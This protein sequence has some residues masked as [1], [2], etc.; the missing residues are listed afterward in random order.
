MAD[1]KRLGIKVIIDM[2]SPPGGRYPNRNLA[3]CYEMQYTNE[4]VKVWERIA[5]HFKGHPALW[6]FDLIN[7]PVQNMPAETDYLTLQ[8]MAAKAIRTIDP[9]VPII[10]A[11]NLWN[12]PETYSYLSPLPLKNIIYQVHMYIPGS[13]T[14]Q[15]VFNTW[16]VDS[17]PTAPLTYPGIIE[18]SKYDRETLRKRLKPV[19]DFQKKYGTRMYVGEFSAIRWAPG[20]ANYL[21]DCISLFEEYQWDWSYHSYREWHGWS[22]EH[23]N[24]PLNRKPVTQDTDRKKVL[25]KYFT[26]NRQNYDITISARIVFKYKK[27][28]EHKMSA[29]K[30]FKLITSAIMIFSN[31]YTYAQETLEKHPPVNTAII[32][33]DP[34]RK[35]GKVNPLIFGNNIEAANGKDIFS[36]KDTEQPLNGQG[37]WNTKADEPIPEVVYIAKEVRMG[38]LRY[39]GG[40]L[41]H[42]FDWRQAVGSKESRTYFKFGIDEYIKLC[43]AIGAEPLMTVSEICTPEDAAD[44]VEYLNMP[45]TP[46]YP[47]AMKRAEWGNNCLLYTSDAADDTPCVDL[48]GRRI[49]KKKKTTK[50]RRA[51]YA[52][53]KNYYART[54]KQH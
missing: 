15:N 32:K 6:G 16:G 8:F 37:A 54:Y 51:R 10:I 12:A 23:S 40:C 13:Y 43:R 35:T 45:A 11:S 24:D 46:Q 42:N 14:H 4:F 5:T 2:H 7:E 47:W 53:L 18:S 30:N 19:I 26:R 1:A 25:L 28:G 31:I 3:M 20:A 41:T 52:P 49:I 39:P 38:M 48:G 17:T 36:D 21:D 27:N 29:K 9:E 44:L 22:V 34:T 33:I 50:T